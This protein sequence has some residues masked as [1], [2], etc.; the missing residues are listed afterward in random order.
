MQSLIKLGKEEEAMDMFTDAI[1][2]FRQ[3]DDVL[4]MA[5]CPNQGSFFVNCYAYLQDC[6]RVPVL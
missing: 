2:Y 4:G 3:V 6:S 5:N 1:S